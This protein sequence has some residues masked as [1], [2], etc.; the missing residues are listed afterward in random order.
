MH[1]ETP[2]H[3]VPIQKV[4]TVNPR[5]VAV[6]RR[7]VDCVVMAD[8]RI[9]W[10]HSCV[11]MQPLNSPHTHD[12]TESPENHVSKRATMVHARPHP[13][14]S[15]YGNTLPPVGVARLP[16]QSTVSTG[17]A[18]PAPPP[19]ARPCANPS[20]NR[21]CEGNLRAPGCRG[22]SGAAARRKTSSRWQTPGQGWGW[23][24]GKGQG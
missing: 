12:L 8:R 11:S 16:L 21:C 1:T 3:H 2:L 20:R 9:C 18:S 24:K 5:S 19:Q 14:H 22:R 23:G 17:R 4:I 13:T 7:R 15:A 6:A 10:A